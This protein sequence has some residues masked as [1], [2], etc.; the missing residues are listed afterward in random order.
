M[1]KQER[2][3]CITVRDYSELKS[4]RNRRLANKKLK[5]IQNSIKRHLIWQNI[6]CKFY[7]PELLCLQEIPSDSGLMFMQNYAPLMNF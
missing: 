2:E 4:K 1:N 3:T 7:Q 6:N 5:N